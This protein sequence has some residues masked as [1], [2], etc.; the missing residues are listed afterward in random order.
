MARY[1]AHRGRGKGAPDVYRIVDVAPPQPEHLLASES[2][3]S[4][5]VPLVFEYMRRTAV[6]RLAAAGAVVA[7]AL[8]MIRTPAPTSAAAGGLSK[9]PSCTRT[10]TE[11][12]DELRGTNGPD[13]ICGL[14]GDDDIHARDGNDIVYG[15]GGSD[16]IFSGD[17]KDRVFGGPRHDDIF[18]GDGYDV[19]FG[20]GGGDLI[21][22]FRDRDRLVGNSGND[23]IDAHAGSD[24]ALGGPGSDG[25]EGQSGRDEI[26]GGPGDD[27]C[28][29][30]NDDDP[31]D[32]LVGGPG[33]DTFEA[34][35]N[36]DR[37]SVERRANCRP[38]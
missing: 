8:L 13:V 6:S 35:P 11:S 4:E 22:G 12:A 2:G 1:G 32:V 10:G 29:W 28:L 24:I 36:D 31:G 3:N 26:R 21:R 30:T 7:L 9:A 14:G 33:V 20:G 27:Y 17:G 18:A 37:R 23:N 15:G 38:Y 19:V 5:A 16:E 34:D 25:I